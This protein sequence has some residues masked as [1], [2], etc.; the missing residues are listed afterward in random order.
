MRDYKFY[1]L[2]FLPQV[3]PPVAKL[4]RATAQRC[5]AHAT[6]L[7]IDGKIHAVY[8]RVLVISA[9][10]SVIKFIHSQTELHCSEARST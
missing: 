9:E 2:H 4:R 6:Y 3:L 8:F 10:S 5:A 1:R 7:L